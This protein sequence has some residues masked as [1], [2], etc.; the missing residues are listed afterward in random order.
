MCSPIRLILDAAAAYRFGV[1]RSQPLVA[2]PANPGT[3]PKDSLI[4]VEPAGVVVTGLQPSGD[5]DA[6]MVRLFA[7]SGQPERAR[8]AYGDG[9]PANAWLSNLDEDQGQECGG[10]VSLSAYGTAT[11]RVAHP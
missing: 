5:G 7:A 6:L 4:R 3:T 1:E 2:V 8:V 11:L 9:R 10:E